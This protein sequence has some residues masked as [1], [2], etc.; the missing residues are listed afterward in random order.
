MDTCR[1]SPLR[2]SSY[3]STFT[4][5]RAFPVLRLALPR[6][7]EL[8]AIDPHTDTDGETHR[9]VEDAIETLEARAAAGEF[10]PDAPITGNAD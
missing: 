5:G 10:D 7:D 4:N 3:W 2:H 6:D 8:T 1:R 9:T